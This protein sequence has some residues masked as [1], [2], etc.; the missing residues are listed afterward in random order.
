MLLPR[1]Q[2]NYDS[3]LI[4]D[5]LKKILR[6]EPVQIPIDAPRLPDSIVSDRDSVFTSKFWF[7]GTTF[8]LDY[9]YSPGL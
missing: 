3:I 2:A 6:D 7:P 4:V 1:R 9:G 5:R 8:D